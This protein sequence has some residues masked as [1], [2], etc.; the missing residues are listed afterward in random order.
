MKENK[1]SKRSMFGWIQRGKKGREEEKCRTDFQLM[2][3]SHCSNTSTLF[4]THTHTHLVFHITQGDREKLS[5]AVS[6][7]RRPFYLLRNINSH[8]TGHRE[9]TA[10]CV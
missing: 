6:A 2:D 7:P 4:Y 8:T 1:D 3:L 5:E 10:V 9:D